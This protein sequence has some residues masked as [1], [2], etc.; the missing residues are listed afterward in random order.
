MKAK[1][2]IDP[3]ELLRDAGNHLQS[4][5]ELLDCAEVT[6][7]IGAHVDLAIHQLEDAIDSCFARPAISN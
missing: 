3:R 7:H 5:L 6:A 1:S 4:A 2:D